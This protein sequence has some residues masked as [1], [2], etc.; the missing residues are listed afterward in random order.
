[1]HAEYQ[2]SSKKDLPA[3]FHLPTPQLRD[4]LDLD[5]IFAL[6]LH[7]SCPLYLEHF[8]DIALLVP[9][10]RV[11]VFIQINFTQQ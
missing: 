7:L 5:L 4:L 1:M 2:N 6:P 9:W 8:L 11:V 3:A 10:R